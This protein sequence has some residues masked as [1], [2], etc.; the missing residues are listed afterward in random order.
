V[1]VFIASYK[2]AMAVETKST[3]EGNINVSFQNN[4]SSKFQSSVN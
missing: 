3:S 2:Y 1:V 4:L